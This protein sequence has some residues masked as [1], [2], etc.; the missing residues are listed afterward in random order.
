MTKAMIEDYNSSLNSLSMIYESCSNEEKPFIESAI[1][2]INQ[3]KC[4]AI[5][6]KK[7]DAMIL[8]ENGELLDE[9]WENFM[10]YMDKEENDAILT[11]YPYMTEAALSVSAALAAAENNACNSKKYNA[12]MAKAIGESLMTM[13]KNFIHSRLKKLA[14]M[15]KLTIPPNKLKRT[16]RGDKMEFSYDGSVAVTA[17]ISGFDKKK[18]VSISVSDQRFKDSIYAAYISATCGIM[19]DT[20]KS[21]LTEAKKLWAKNKKGSEKA[22]K[23]YVEEVWEESGDFS[24][25]K[26]NLDM[27]VTEGKTSHF[28]AQF[29]TRVADAAEMKLYLKDR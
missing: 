20:I 11:A 3:A 16:S 25:I 28:A 5:S 12:I 22:I 10:E 6:Q 2:S 26:E 21:E 17:T 8:Y 14:V 1:R 7:E 13:E 15:K 18:K 24:S 29:F 27:A 19:T 4:E 23:E 9:E